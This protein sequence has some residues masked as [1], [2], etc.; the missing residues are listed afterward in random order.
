MPG[1]PGA[2]AGPCGPDGPGGPAEQRACWA[3]GTGAS[4]CRG[5]L[6]ARASLFGEKSPHH[7]GYILQYVIFK[8]DTLQDCVVIHRIACG[9]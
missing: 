5:A 9:H 3:G 8:V 7:E 4:G 1:G 6:L 2:P